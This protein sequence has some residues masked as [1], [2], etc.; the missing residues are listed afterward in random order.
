VKVGPL[1]FA[2]VKAGTTHVGDNRG[3]WI[4][5]SQRPRHEVRLPAFL[6]LESPLSTSEVADLVGSDETVE[7]GVHEGIDAALLQRICAAVRPLV[8]EGFEV[9]PPSMA[10]WTHARESGVLKPQQ[11]ALE[12]LADAPF[13]NH[14]GAPMDGRPREGSGHGPLMEQLACIEVHPQK[15]GATATS[16]VP[17]DRRLPGTVLR[18]VLSPKR[19]SPARTVPK[20]ADRAANLRIEVL[21][22]LLIGV[23]PSFLIPV[24][25]G[26]GSYALEGWGNL[27]FGGLVAGFVTGAVW[28]PRRPTVTWDDGEIHDEDERSVSQ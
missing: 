1:T 15:A 26:F 28:R 9:R 4:H 17:M 27:L 13:S 3:G 5:A 16:S 11:G 14:R 10:E 19:T 23:V 21:S 6:I 24:V 20:Q 25:R 2:E 12:V 18:L 7:E 8:D 22:T